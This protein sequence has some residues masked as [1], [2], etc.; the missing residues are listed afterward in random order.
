MT[1]GRHR[2][3]SGTG[4]GHR[5]GLGLAALVL[6]VLACVQLPGTL[7]AWSDGS[8]ATTGTLTAGS[9]DLQLAAEGG[10]TGAV[11][12]G[13]AF[14]AAAI[15]WSGLSPGERRAFELTVRNVGSPPMSWS[16]TARQGAT[17]AWTF[18]GDPVTVQLFE[19]TRTAVDTTYPVEESCTGTALG[20]VRAVGTSAAALVTAARRVAPGAL[21][22]VCAVVG[23]ATD[24]TNA[25]QGKRGAVV[26][27][28]T[29]AQ[30]T[31]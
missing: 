2:A 30:A 10:A 3:S 4:R 26:L 29:G 20:P 23:L 19:G 6:A 24:A 11:G 31:S 9:M 22:R 12:L 21:D 8:A 25:N 5:T 15:T 7:A 18:T 16:A 17:P 28:L 13:T 27:D 1:A 14:D